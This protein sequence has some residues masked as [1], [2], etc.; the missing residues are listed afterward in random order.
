MVDS[1]NNVIPVRRAYLLLYQ[2]HD[3]VRR[4]LGLAIARMQ[5]APRQVDQ[6]D[7]GALPAGPA[8][9]QAVV[10]SHCPL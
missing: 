9:S 3:V 10:S 6:G 7:V 1:S 4:A 5:D 8:Y 2:L